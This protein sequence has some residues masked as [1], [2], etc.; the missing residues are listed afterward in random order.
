MSMMNNTTYL[1]SDVY[2]LNEIVRGA[3][4]DKSLLY[5]IVRVLLLFF[6]IYNSSSITPYVFISTSRLAL[7]VILVL[8]LIRYNGH[9]SIS[10]DYTNHS[11]V[12]NLKFQVFLLTYNA[13]QLLILG[14][15]TGSNLLNPIIVFLITVPISVYLFSLLY[16]DAE[17]LME[18]FI[19]ITVIQAVI[20]FVCLFSSGF[21]SFIDST[22]NRNIIINQERDYI[23]MRRGGYN[24]GLACITSIGSLKMALGII[25]CCYFYIKG[26]NVL[27]TS[28]AFAFITA[29]SLT[30]ARSGLVISIVMLIATLIFTIREK[31]FTLLKILISMT[32]VL[33][34]FYDFIFVSNSELFPT[35]FYR[36][37]L[38]MENGV[39]ETF[40]DGY[41]NSGESLPLFSDQMLFGTGITSGYSGNG[42]YINVDGN[43]RRIYSAIGLPLTIVFYCVIM[44]T[45]IKGTRRIQNKHFGYTSILMI[46]LMVYGEFKEPYFYSMYLYIFFFVFL[47]CAMKEQKS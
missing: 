29:A 10:K 28:F 22:F 32:V 18:D 4:T 47:R 3:Q 44:F 27:I 37:N 38:L 7:L 30:T 21:S 12:F 45:M 24:G 14:S 17:E 23:A 13:F 15:G 16:T 39:N 46:L 31:N 40:F 33:M 35:M 6:T 5:R 34:F 26:K 20:M 43:V 36:F 9:L 42:Y 19:I 25:G 11:L 8:F 2:A 41:M 1:K